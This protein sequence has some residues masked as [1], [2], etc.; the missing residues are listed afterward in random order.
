M[1]FFFLFPHQA[2]CMTEF[3]LHCAWTWW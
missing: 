3:A 1:G 2:G